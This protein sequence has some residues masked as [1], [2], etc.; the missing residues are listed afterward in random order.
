[1]IHDAT[2]VRDTA[3]DAARVFTALAEMGDDVARVI[4]AV[5]T[6]L[7]SGGT[8]FTCGNGGS[9]AEALHLAEELIGR[10]KADRPPLRAICL[11]SDPTALTCI[12]NDY[13]FDRVFAR[14]VEGLARAGDCLVALSTSGHSQNIRLAL[15]QARSM[16]VTTIALLGKDGG[17]CK[18]LCD[19][20]LVMPSQ[21]TERIQEAHLLVI[22]QILEALERPRA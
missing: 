3:L 4:D 6:T 20:A 13:G 12:A 8:V 18:D 7:A 11:S 17:A 16:G 15:E 19:H 10:Y 5:R 14:Q 2:L 21:A 9:A 22:H 1:M